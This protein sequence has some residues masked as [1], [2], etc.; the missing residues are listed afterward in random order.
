MEAPSNLP[1]HGQCIHYMAGLPCNDG[2]LRRCTGAHVE[3]C[4]RP[5]CPLYLSY[6]TCP[7]GAAC[8]FPHVIE[9]PVSRLSPT[10][11][12]QVMAS[13]A[14]RL[15]HYLAD[16]FKL[17]ASALQQ[18]RAHGFS[19]VDPRVILLEVSTQQ[20]DDIQA[21]LASD[22]VV[23][24]SL[25]RMYRLQAR[26]NSFEAAIAELLMRLDSL[27]SCSSCTHAVRLRVQA[28]PRAIENEVCKAVEAACSSSRPLCVTPSDF[29]AVACLVALP[30]VCYCGVAIATPGRGPGLAGF[31]QHMHT[32]LSSLTPAGECKRSRAFCK[33]QEV[34]RRTHAFNGVRGCSALDVGA[35]PGGWS[36]FLASDTVGAACVVAVDGA[37][38][39]QSQPLPP[40][41]QHWQMKVTSRHKPFGILV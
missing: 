36:S 24:K 19:R 5:P 33:L 34:G 9:A 12:L 10:L 21:F 26:T 39:D 11:A 27:V 2:S 25:A 29:N 14:D 23:G 38:L 1:H 8:W 32:Q 17:P 35:A 37:E 28:Y 41:I 7:R 6:D 13:H 20:A 4:N 15:Q 3:K 30:G 22:P 18:C 31:A 40:A 16:V